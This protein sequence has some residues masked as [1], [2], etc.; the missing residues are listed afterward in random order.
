MAVLAA[1]AAWRIC[2]MGK[3]ESQLLQNAHILLAMLRALIG[4]RL[5]L[6]RGLRF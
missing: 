6:E 2:F 4:L 3:G 5:A 1:C